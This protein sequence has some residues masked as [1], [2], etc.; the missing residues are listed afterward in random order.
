M[1]LRPKLLRSRIAL[2]LGTISG[3]RGAIEA[4]L[5]EDFPSETPRLFAKMLLDLA[6][7]LERMLSD[8][9]TS[10]TKEIAGAKN[11]SVRAER[12]AL[13]WY[14][15]GGVFKFASYLMG[16]L[17]FLP[18]ARA[19]QDPWGLVAQLERLCQSLSPNSRVIVGPGRGNT[20]GYG[21]G[22]S[23]KIKGEA[24]K[25]LGSY[26]GNNPMLRILDLYPEFFTLSVPPTE[27][28]DVLRVAAFGHEV[29]HSL[30]QIK[31][32]PKRIMMEILEE[33]LEQIGSLPNANRWRDVEYARNQVLN[34]LNNWLGEIMADVFSAHLLGPAALFV[35]TELALSVGLIDVFDEEHPPLR[36]R[37]R[38]LREELTHLGYVSG[39]DVEE[40]QLSLGAWGQK[41][42][43][44]VRAAVEKEF[45]Y[46][47]AFL[48]MEGRA[49]SQE[50]LVQNGGAVGE[51][52]YWTHI[53]AHLP[54]IVEH[55]RK[56][57][58]AL[59]EESEDRGGPIFLRPDDL[60][61]NPQHDVNQAIALLSK[62]VPPNCMRE[63][64][65]EGIRQVGQLTFA[66]LLNA[67]WL[68]WATY[69]KRR[70][71]GAPVQYGELCPERVLVDRLVLKGIELSEAQ[72]WFAVREGRLPRRSRPELKRT[73]FCGQAK[74]DFHA[75]GVLSAD[76]ICARINRPLDE[77]SLII[78][79]MLDRSAQI[80]KSSVDVRLGTEFIVAKHMR[81][82][83]LDPT[84][85]EIR[86]RIMEYQTKV[87]VAPGKPLILQPQQF[88]LG[89]TLEYLRLPD[90]LAGLVI[91]RS[92]WG[93]LGLVIA[94]AS[95]VEPGFHGCLTLELVNLGGIPLS[96][97]PCSRIGQLV[98]YTVSRTEIGKE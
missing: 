3:V 43:K 59:R 10:R 97:Y 7:E 61:S 69:G 63:L 39:I 80:G 42:E 30:P 94:T 71:G 53:A 74:A 51:P 52:D 13:L 37:L 36:A 44:R 16:C 76:E 57:V 91:G 82:P 90:D 27:P 26:D 14:W 89:S 68:Y 54:A 98:L 24:G 33:I 73:D 15:M 11:D 22:S 40:A 66:I 41:L 35:L 64:D 1:K 48:K 5:T 62:S 23:A 67:G 75:G 78:T 79:P 9:Y 8:G 46:V 18:G 38:V 19:R 77:N 60:V 88:V 70:R 31:D 93:R 47:D 50:Q 87:Y 29:G 12:S 83:S 25:Y 72:Y 85:P 2:I 45:R 58:S 21:E 6:E 56:R 32:I 92:S 84:D 34:L 86:A 20:Y 49:E 96:L 17:H 65:A 28:L 81:L 95:H 55:V 4:E